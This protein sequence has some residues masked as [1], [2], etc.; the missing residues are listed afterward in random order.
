M[1]SISTIRKIEDGDLERVD[2]AA[3]RFIA[4]HN[5][6]DDF[7]DAITAI[8]YHIYSSWPD[9]AARCRQA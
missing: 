2:R 6:P 4:R 8:Q 7:D 3:K 5:I 1:P 9:D